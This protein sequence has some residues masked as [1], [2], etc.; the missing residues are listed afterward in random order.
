MGRTFKYLFFLLLAGFL[1]ISVFAQNR[2]LV[3]TVDIVVPTV[4]DLQIT[5]GAN[6]VVDFNQ[7]SK[8]DNGI[9]LLAATSLTYRSNKDWFIT[10]KAG[11]ANFIGGLAG[12]PMPA[13]VIKYRVS[14]IGAN[15]IPLST[16]EQ[17]LFPA[18]GPRGTGSGTIDFKIDPGYNYAP[19]QNY[20]LQV[21]YTIS[22]L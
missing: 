8:I 10:I 13:S 7:T 21:I 3:K 9:E 6:P 4:L 11:S 18:I 1:N 12:S 2:Y 15:Y 5:S 14:G 19:A 20:S 16:I 22:N 17:P